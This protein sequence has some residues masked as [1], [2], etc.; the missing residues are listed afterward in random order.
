MQQRARSKSLAPSSRLRMPI[1]SQDDDTRLL[2]R[3][4]EL[5]PNPRG[6]GKQGVAKLCA[7]FGKERHYLSQL[8]ARTAPLKPGEKVHQDDPKKGVPTKL[9][10]EKDDSMQE[11]A[12]EWGFNFSYQEM[13][14]HLIEVFEADSFSISRQAVAD[15]L[16]KADWNL[17]HTSRVSPLLQQRL[18]HFA[19]RAAFAKANK[20]NK[21]KNWVWV[22]EAW[23]YT[24]ALRILLKLPSDQFAPKRRVRHKSH[25]AKLMFLIALARPRLDDDFDGKIGVWVVGEEYL[26]VYNTPN[27]DA[28]DEK[29]RSYTL[30]ANRYQDLMVDEVFPAIRAAFPDE[31][32][33]YVQHDGTPPHTGKTPGKKNRSTPVVLAE[34]GEKRKRGEPRIEM[35]EQPAQSPDFNLC[36]LAFLRALACSVRK[37]RRLGPGEKRSFDLKELADDVKAEFDDY[38]AEKIEDMVQ[39]L[40]YVLNESLKTDPKGGND[41]P[42][43]RSAEA[44]KRKI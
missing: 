16:R 28:G 24:E 38:P 4:H 21:F 18:G 35:V 12:V 11:Q 19:K 31:E 8:I 25:V 33:V 39:H 26:A 20:K 34:A 36:D 42:R 23:L 10:P 15:H 2:A 7:E 32:V 43:H 29:V 44:K 14:D 37:R 17:N 13:A 1:L 40:H 27:Q 3:Y 30:N 9:T 22:D 5:R 6:R 41:Y